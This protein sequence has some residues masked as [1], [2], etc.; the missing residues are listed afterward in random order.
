M[1]S[2]PLLFIPISIELRA[3]YPMDMK[4]VCNFEKVL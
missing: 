2:P 3:E 1:K 4:E